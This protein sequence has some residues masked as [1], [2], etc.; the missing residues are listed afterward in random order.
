MLQVLKTLGKQ[1]LRAFYHEGKVSWWHTGCLKNSSFSRESYYLIRHQNPYHKIIGLTILFLRAF[2]EITD[3]VKL[4][5]R[6]SDEIFWYKWSIGIVCWTLE[7]EIFL[8]PMKIQN[9]CKLFLCWSWLR[10]FDGSDTSPLFIKLTPYS[11]Q[12]G[13]QKNFGHSL[14]M[15]NFWT[16]FNAFVYF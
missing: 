5:R 6:L 1:L 13:W 9:C 3:S 15:K 2:W 8:N 12:I 11:G 4:G 10:F 16:F 7:Y 14:I